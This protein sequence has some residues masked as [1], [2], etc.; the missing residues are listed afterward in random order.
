MKSANRCSKASYSRVTKQPSMTMKMENGFRLSWI[1]SALGP[2]HFV[3]M[4]LPIVKDQNSERV[5]KVFAS[6]REVAELRD[7]AEF[8]ME[9]HDP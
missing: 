7:K 3:K 9:R 1:G 6:T 4:P 2:S 5:A 8:P